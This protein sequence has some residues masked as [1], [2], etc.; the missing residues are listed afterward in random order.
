VML[1]FTGSMASMAFRFPGFNS[2]GALPTMTAHLPA[3]ERKG[4]GYNSLPSLRWNGSFP[5]H[6][7]IYVSV[8]VCACVRRYSYSFVFIC[9]YSIYLFTGHLSLSIYPSIHLSI[10][11]VV[12]CLGLSCPALPCP[13]TSF[14]V[15]SSRALSIYLRELCKLSIHA[16]YVIYEIYIIYYEWSMYLWNPCNL[17]CQYTLHGDMYYIVFIYCK[18]HV[19]R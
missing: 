14:P 7:F 4:M 17:W 15:L 8:W 1:A 10:C 2:F 13:I 3:R 6:K 12:S 19:H 9:P 11:L 5:L 16:T 18:G